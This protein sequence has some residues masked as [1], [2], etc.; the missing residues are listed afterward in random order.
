MWRDTGRV[1]CALTE[2]EEYEILTCRY[3]TAG[4]VEGERV[5]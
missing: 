2:S 4:N 3:L 1:G 5:F